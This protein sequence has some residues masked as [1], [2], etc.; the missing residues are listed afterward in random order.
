MKN[1]GIRTKQK[2]VITREDLPTKLP[3][4]SSISFT[5]AA[6]GS[7]DGSSPLSIEIPTKITSINGLAGGTLTSPLT[8]TGGDGNTAKIALNQAGKGQI[9]DSGT[10]TLFGFLSATELSIGSPSYITRLRG[11]KTKPTYNGND[12]A[13]FSDI[14]NGTL[15]IKQGGVS[16]G[17]FTANQSGNTEIDL[18]IAPTVTAGTTTTLSA[19][20]NATVTNSGTNT[21]AVFN[22]GIPRGTTF[23]PSVSSAGVLSWSNDGGKTNPAN[24]NIKGATGATGAAALNYTENVTLNSEGRIVANAQYFNRTPVSGDKCNFVYAPDG[25]TYIVSGTYYSASA[26]NKYIFTKDYQ[27][28]NMNGANGAAGLSYR[29]QYPQTD[30]ITGNAT[31]IPTAGMYLGQVIV[32]GRDYPTKLDTDGFAPDALG[33]GY[34]NIVYKYAPQANS[35]DGAITYIVTGTIHQITTDGVIFYVTA[36]SA[37]MQGGTGGTSTSILPSQI[38]G[39]SDTQSLFVGCDNQKIAF[40]VGNKPTYCGTNTG[41]TWGPNGFGISQGINE[42]SGIWFDGDGINMWSPCDRDAITYYDEDD[43][44]KVFRVSNTG[45]IYRKDG[46][47]AL[48]TGDKTA[49]PYSLSIT[50]DGTTTTYDGSAA[51]SITITTPTIPTNYVTTDTEQTITG[52]KT[53]GSNNPVTVRL[54]VANYSS[55]GYNG[56]WVYQGA[57]SGAKATRYYCGKITNRDVS[58]TDYIL[59]LPLKSGTIA[60]TSDITGGGGSGGGLFRHDTVISDT[61]Q[62]INLIVTMYTSSEQE[63]NNANFM[64]Y[65]SYFGGAYLSKGD[66]N[67]TKLIYLSMNRNGTD[68]QKLDIEVCTEAFT[69]IESLTINIADIDKVFFSDTVTQ[70]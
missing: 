21:A 18:G 27:S 60:L 56:F 54:D 6:T 36:V 42:T 70:C 52:K 47:A 23:T 46:K 44:S 15:T 1:L 22:F 41:I 19:S 4:P 32:Q 24:V 10:A 38:K 62:S 66:L 39:A 12:L 61:D 64:N 7:Y 58:G 29:F 8:L 53:F 9:T 55:Y 35:D 69:G 14:G 31:V 34:A 2:D 59:T 26:D 30:S 45:I 65:I 51:K 20:S 43:G 37:P 68:S 50:Y 48:Y 5:G 49:C 16:K 25:G 63:L 28:P 67:G 13:L 3:N 33:T 57:T 17:T 40:N 11:S